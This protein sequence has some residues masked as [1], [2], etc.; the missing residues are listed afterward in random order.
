MHLQAEGWLPPELRPREERDICPSSSCKT[1]TMST[2][3][4]VPS[5]PS[6]RAK[7]SWLKNTEVVDLLV[8]H[9]RYRLPVSSD[10]PNKPAGML[11]Y[12][13]AKTE[14]SKEVPECGLLC[15]RPHV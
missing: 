15:T 14:L 10:P 6:A 13:R 5:R 9:E 7:T 1:G 11:R 8:N 2:Y 4:P 12:L 3:R